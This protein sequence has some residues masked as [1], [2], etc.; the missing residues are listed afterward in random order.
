MSCVAEPLEQRLL[1]AT[2]SGIKWNDVN[3]NGTQS[4]AGEVGLAG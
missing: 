2:V 4:G 1:L 3:G